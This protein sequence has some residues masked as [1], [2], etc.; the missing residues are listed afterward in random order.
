M[1]VASGSGA[2]GGTADSSNITD[3][4]VNQIASLASQMEVDQ[5]EI[6]AIVEA[7]QIQEYE[8][9]IELAQQ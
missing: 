7:V 1:G 5:D 2:T 4:E 3:Q 9:N 8:N 6:D